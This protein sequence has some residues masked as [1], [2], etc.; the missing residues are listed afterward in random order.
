MS[1]ERL[2]GPYGAIRLRVV[3][4]NSTGRPRTLRGPPVRTACPTPDRPRTA[5]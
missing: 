3:L 2:P 1:A 5:C 4:E